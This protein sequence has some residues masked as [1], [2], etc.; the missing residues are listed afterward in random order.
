MYKQLDIIFDF[1]TI[2]KFYNLRVLKNYHTRCISQLF[3]VSTY[4]GFNSESVLNTVA[5]KLW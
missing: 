3:H 2:L 5:V 4:Y 1:I